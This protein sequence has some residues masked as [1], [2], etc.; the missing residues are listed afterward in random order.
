MGKSVFI[1]FYNTMFGL[2][3]E[4]SFKDIPQD[5][6]ITT[7]L[8]Y[9]K[10]ADAVVFHIPD[11]KQILGNKELEK[12]EGVLWVAWNLECE[13][14][15]PWVEYEGFRELFDL[16]M[17]YHNH[18]DI[19]YSYCKFSYQDKFKLPIKQY[20]VKNRICMFISSP[21]NK[22]HR[23]EYLY[24]LMKYTAIDSYGAFCNNQVLCVDTGSETLLNVIKDYNL[25][26]AFENA[27]ATD[28]VTVKFYNPLLA[29][30]VPIYFGAPNIHSFSPGENC[31][32]DVTT[33]ETPYKL[34]EFINRCY[35]DNSL[36]NSFFEWK[37]KPLLQ[38]FIDRT[39]Q[40]R[41]D[42]IVRLCHK[43]QWLKTGK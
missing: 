38:D 4:Y 7:D 3:L 21:F 2:P 22:S 27:I 24:E 29:G 37:Q 5:C 36:Y 17:G 6:Y 20:P 39:D 13:V 18:D 40:E 12:P 41:I 23:Q 15:Y 43:V 28:Y 33:F 11:L 35:I 16:W 8:A 1:L 10:L 26:I 19:I 31:F 34:A 30:T 9:L 42:P 25:M 14:N 32:V